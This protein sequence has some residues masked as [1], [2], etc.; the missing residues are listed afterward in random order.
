MELLVLGTMAV[1]G[2]QL[3]YFHHTKEYMTRQAGAEVSL[4]DYDYMGQQE[5][6]RPTHKGLTIHQATKDSKSRLLENFYR[7]PKNGGTVRRKQNRGAGDDFMHDFAMER[8][9]HKDRVKVDLDFVGV[10]KRQKMKPQEILGYELPRH[11]DI[12]GM[13][14]RDPQY[15]VRE[16]PLDEDRIK[17]RKDH[18][19]TYVDKVSP[20]FTKK[21]N[22]VRKSEVLQHR[23]NRADLSI[24]LANIEDIKFFSPITND[25]YENI[26]RSATKQF[27][28]PD[29]FRFEVE[30]RATERYA[31]GKPN[32]QIDIPTIRD[33]KKPAPERSGID[34]V[35]G[36]RNDARFDEV[37]VPKTASRTP[38]YV[39]IDTNNRKSGRALS[40]LKEI[41]Y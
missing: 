2:Y 1:L 37:P 8:R 20:Y 25:V 33:I 4:R 29:T 11:T 9:Q 22:D 17:P 40:Q 3:P 18:V 19:Q 32:M 12:S 5:R 15:K 28:K 21:V 39:D 27:A 13:T 10:E 7:N 34:L 24:P 6:R 41:V 31:T 16:R 30:K 26:E 14:V 38:K 35:P 23:Q 36:R